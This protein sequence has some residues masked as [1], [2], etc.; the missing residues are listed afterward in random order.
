ML[1]IV[2]GLLAISAGP[3]R[4]DDDGNGQASKCTLHQA[5]VNKVQSQLLPVTQLPDGN[6][7][8]FKPN[9]MWSAVVDRDGHLCSIVNTDGKNGDAWP[10]SRAIAIAK[11]ETANDFS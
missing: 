6:G 1:G 10:G 11:A 5:V 3:I 4:A 8:I 9:R 2:V 7:G